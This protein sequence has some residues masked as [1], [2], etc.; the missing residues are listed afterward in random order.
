MF[1]YHVK[2]VR[3]NEHVQGVKENGKVI[4]VRTIPGYNRPPSAVSFMPVLLV[5]VGGYIVNL[6]DFYSER[7]IGKLTAFL[8]LQE[9]SL[10]RHTQVASSPPAAR[11]SSRSFRAK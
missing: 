11:L 7:L 1:F 8:Q 4:P 10:R 6:L 3:T 5:R 9:F 2:F